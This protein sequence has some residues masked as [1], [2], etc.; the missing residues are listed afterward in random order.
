VIR[1]PTSTLKETTSRCQGNRRRRSRAWPRLSEK[2]GQ[3]T[4]SS[5]TSASAA[6]LD[7]RHHHRAD[8]PGLLALNKLRVNQ[9]PTSSS[10]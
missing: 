6:G 9:I 2:Y 5:P 8:V 7:G 3:L 1:Y 4:M 10:R